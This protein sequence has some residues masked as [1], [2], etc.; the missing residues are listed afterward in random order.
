MLGWINCCGRPSLELGIAPIVF[1]CVH[2]SWFLSGVSQP[3]VRGHTI[4]SSRKKSPFH[5][6]SST[7]RPHASTLFSPIL[8]LLRCRSC[9][10]VLALAMP[11]TRRPWGLCATLS[12]QKGLGLGRSQ[13]PAEERLERAQALSKRPSWRGELGIS[14]FPCV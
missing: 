13:T 12:A 4:K 6:F 1:R 10:R 3:V 9:W 8:F 14:F 2:V 7:W 11:T 5:I